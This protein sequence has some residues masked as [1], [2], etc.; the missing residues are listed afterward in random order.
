VQ[1]IR[2]E[3]EEL[4][5][6]LDWESSA[7]VLDVVIGQSRLL[8]KRHQLNASP[9]G[10]CMASR[11]IPPAAVGSAPRGLLS[12]SVTIF[13]LNSCGLRLACTDNNLAH[14]DKT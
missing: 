8:Q 4:D 14:D 12:T 6:M 7:A 9:S 10:A 2:H 5:L 13:A 3:I 11:A 1:G